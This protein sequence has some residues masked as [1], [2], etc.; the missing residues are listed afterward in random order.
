MCK[1]VFIGESEIA[2]QRDEDSTIGKTVALNRSGPQFHP[3][4]P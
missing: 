2:S 3:Q 1:D 4:H